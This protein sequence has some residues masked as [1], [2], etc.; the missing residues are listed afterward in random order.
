M[1]K[2]AISGAS[3]GTATFTIESPATSTNRTLTLPDAAGTMFNQGNIL[4]TVSESSGVPTG[5][6][7]ERGSN[8]NGEFVKFADGTMLCIPAGDTASGIE[9]L[10]N[11]GAATPLTV[12]LPATFADTSFSIG[13]TLGRDSS[14]ATT[15]QILFYVGSFT[16]TT[17]IA[18]AWNL[19]PATTNQ[20]RQFRYIGVGR[21]F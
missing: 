3:T 9:I 12:T 4:G 18:R 10:A 6:I 7:I 2:I 5:A 13:I 19:N 20:T 15:S 21:W 17:F 16:T 1:S 11:Q 14:A 8:A